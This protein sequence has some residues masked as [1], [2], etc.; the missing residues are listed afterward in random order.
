MSL[1]N[2]AITSYLSYLFHFVHDLRVCYLS[3]DVLPLCVR[4]EKI[5]THTVYLEFDC[6]EGK[7]VEFLDVLLPALADTRAFEGCISVETFIN[8]DAPDTVFLWEKWEE[9]SNQEAYMG[10]RV[11]TGLLDLI[12]PFMAGPPKIAHLEAKD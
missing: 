11:E 2:L 10:W 4:K 7:G 1:V 12:G 9:R 5:M 8:A 6:A 3:R